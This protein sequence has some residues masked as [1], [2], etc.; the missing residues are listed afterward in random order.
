[1][2]PTRRPTTVPYR[3]RAS[4]SAGEQLG[5]LLGD[6]LNDQTEVTTPTDSKDGQGLLS[7]R[8][9][10]GSEPGEVVVRSGTPTADDPAFKD[11]IRRLPQGA[12]AATVFDAAAV[13]AARVEDPPVSPDRDAVLVA[14]PTR[15][16]D[17]EAGGAG[18]AAWAGALGQGCR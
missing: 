2:Q 10:G 15:T 3:P 11:Q 4:R 13:A 8:I 16:D 1:M 14:L 7:G 6:A 17:V 9:G 12:L 5:S 18:Q